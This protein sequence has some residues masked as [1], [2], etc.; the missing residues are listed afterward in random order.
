MI[1]CS[2]KKS[3]EFRDRERE[4][5]RAPGKRANDSLGC[6]AALYTRKTLYLH[7]IRLN[8]LKAQMGC[9]QMVKL[10]APSGRSSGGPPWPTELK[11]QQNERIRGVVGCNV[12]S[13]SGPD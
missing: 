5:K 9:D 8:T 4:K 1:N 13:L 11:G 7:M 6:R 12:G 3:Y 2:K 10:G